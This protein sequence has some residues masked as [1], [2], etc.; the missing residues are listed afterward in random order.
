MGVHNGTSKLQQYTEELW[1]DYTNDEDI[2][3]RKSGN[4]LN[5]KPKKVKKL[6]IQHPKKKVSQ[7][8]SAT[9]EESEDLKEIRE[10]L[11]DNLAV[12]FGSLV[13]STYKKRV[14]NR[15]PKAKKQT[16]QPVNLQDELNRSDD[17]WETML[18]RNN[19]RELNKMKR[20]FVKEEKIQKVQMLNKGFVRH[21]KTATSDESEVKSPVRVRPNKQIVK[22]TKMIKKQLDQQIELQKQKQQKKN[23]MEKWSQKIQ[24]DKK[25]QQKSNRGKE[26]RFNSII[27]ER[28]QMKEE[29]KNDNSKPKSVKS[30][31][32]SQ[33]DEIRKIVQKQVEQ[34]KKQKEQESIKARKEL[35]ITQKEKKHEKLMKQ[36][37][38]IQMVQKANKKGKN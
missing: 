27:Q 31:P 21:V 13:Q 12:G 4:N 36:Q 18:Y 35:A 3:I 34:Q 26:N 11:E 17:G 33:G 29:I 16:T 24:N 30:R 6:V 22:N 9:S 38:H 25:K 5:S 15:K 1:N 23:E 28:Q 37:K 14:R 19:K 7:P 32:L 8:S 2:I 10:F 20:D